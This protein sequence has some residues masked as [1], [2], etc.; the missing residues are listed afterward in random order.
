MR[1]AYIQTHMT[2]VQQ[3]RTRAGVKNRIHVHGSLRGSERPHLAADRAVEVGVGPGFVYERVVPPLVDVVAESSADHDRAGAATG[4][5]WP[6]RRSWGSRCASARR[7]SRTSSPFPGARRCGSASGPRCCRGCG[8]CARRCSRAGTVQPW[9]RLGSRSPCEPSF[10]IAPPLDE[11]VHGTLRAIG[12]IH[13]QR[14]PLGL[15]GVLCAREGRRR[16]G[17]IITRGAR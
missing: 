7:R 15:G 10:E 11:V 12:V 2:S 3:T 8:R 17:V 14:K 9:V 1:V 5:P 13:E 6:P 16:F 4:S